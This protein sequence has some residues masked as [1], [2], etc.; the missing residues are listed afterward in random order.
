MRRSITRRN[1]LLA[2]ALTGLAGCQGLAE[3][4]SPGSTLEEAT[5][6]RYDLALAH[7]P[8]AW[9]AYDPDWSAPTD[10]KSVV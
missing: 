3:N 9:A 7:E 8:T 1:F 4:V 10:R 6:G 2:G 5:L